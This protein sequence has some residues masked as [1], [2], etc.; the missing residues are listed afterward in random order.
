MY[1]Y[2]CAWACAQLFSRVQLC[3]PM[4]CS[5]P[6]SSVHVISQARILE[7]VAISSSGGGGGGRS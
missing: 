6:S 1:M 3:A 2:T 7:S 4:D 5:Q